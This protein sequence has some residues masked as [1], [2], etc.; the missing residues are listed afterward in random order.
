MFARIRQLL[1][2][3]SGVGD[4]V[5]VLTGRYAGQTGTVTAVSDAGVTVYL[6]EWT[7]PTLAAEAVRTLRRN[8]STE[9]GPRD[10]GT[11]VDYEEAR[12]RIRQIP[13]SDLV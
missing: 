6:D 2:R 11:D 1:R 7:E 13:P 3:R 4:V 12:T 10:A 8:Q 5:T 9:V